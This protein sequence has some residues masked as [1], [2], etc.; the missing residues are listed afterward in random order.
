MDK[1]QVGELKILVEQL[2]FP[3]GPAFAP[4]GSLWL[5][6][7]QGKSLVRYDNGKVE[8]F[9][10]GGK[11][12]GIAIDRAGLIW[13][14][15][16]EMDAIRCFDPLEGRARIVVD[17]LDG[18]RLDHPNDLVFDTVGNL[19]FTCPGNSRQ[20]P[21][22]YV[23]VLKT[24]GGI[25]K[26]AEGKFF[27]N[28]LAFVDQGRQLIIA[29]TYRQRLFKGD[30][31]VYNTE[32][33]EK[34]IFAETGGPIGPDGMAVTAAGEVYVAVYGSA[35]IK[36][37]GPDGTYRSSILLPGS[38]PTNCA[39]DPTGKQGLVITE[40]EKGLLLSYV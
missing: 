10:V 33:S 32:F 29:E 1:K 18:Q 14:C 38:N 31:D 36:V 8:R 37:F 15:D 3:E 5:V 13:F 12:N 40:A 7:L 23:C 9:E 22:G 39:F 19:L 35:K 17:Q 16:A 6:E 34:D 11:P 25:K 24:D 26:V 4:D 30:W 28:G 27:P 20:E 2:R 21:T